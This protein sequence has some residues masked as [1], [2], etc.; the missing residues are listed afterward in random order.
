MN[1]LTFCSTNNRVCCKRRTSSAAR[2]SSS[3]NRCPCH[4]LLQCCVRLSMNCWTNARPKRFCRAHLL[5]HDLFWMTSI[6]IW[7]SARGLPLV[8]STEKA[9]YWPSKGS[10]P[11]PCSLLVCLFFLLKLLNSFLFTNIVLMFGCIIIRYMTSSTDRHPLIIYGAEGSGK[12]CLVAR[13]AQQ[14]HN[15]QPPDPTTAEMGLILRFARLTPQ[16]CTA[17]SL[18]A[19]LTRQVS[20]IL[21]GRIPHIPHV[22]NK[23]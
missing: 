16:S 7:H 17:L 5:F 2:C 13:A 22:N 6:N 21:T 12:T 4:P 1:E 14:C 11:P 19:S 23:I 8:A 20:L 15:W 9:P 18:L 3:S 10:P